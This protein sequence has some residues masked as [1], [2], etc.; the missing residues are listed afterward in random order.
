MGMKIGLMRMKFK[1]NTS[2]HIQSVHVR[3]H[4]HAWTVHEVAMIVGIKDKKY[5]QKFPNFIRV[6][7]ENL[8]CFE[9]GHG[10]NKPLN[11]KVFKAVEEFDH[12]Q[13]K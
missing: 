6:A 12:A 1:F 3:G 9:H 2:V 10:M 8:L 4:E 13:I 7:R 5:E 11:H